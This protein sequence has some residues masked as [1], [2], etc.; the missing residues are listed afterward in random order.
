M[1]YDAHMPSND[2]GVISPTAAISSI[3]YTPK[4]SMAVIRNL[5]ENHKKE[6]W[7]EAGF[8]DAI[9]LQNNWSAKRYLAIDQGPEVVMIENY[10][11][12]LLWKLFMNAPE[13]KQG[14]VKLGFKSGKY[15]I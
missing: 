4:E 15:G 11:S 13:V 7:G 5:Y 14:L 2:K 3:V 6:T 10:R 1:G 12:G 8:Y 9:S